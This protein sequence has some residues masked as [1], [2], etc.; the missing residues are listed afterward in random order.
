MSEFELIPEEVYE[1]LPQD[2]HEKFASI[3]RVAQSN[4][5]RLLDTPSSRDFYDE[6]RAQFISA[7]SGV[8]EALGIDGLPPIDDDITEYRSYANFQI[9]LA[10]I[11]ARV[12]LQSN[13]VSRPHSVELGRITRA[14]IKQEIDQ[15]RKYIEYSD[16]PQEKRESLA[17]KLDEFEKELEARRMSFARVMAISASIMTIIGAGTTALAN[18][19]KAADAII[20]IIHWVGED[21]EKEESERLRLMPPPKALPDFTKSAQWKQRPVSFA[22]EADDDIPF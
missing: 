12:R 6:I 2:P 16:I 8:A 5:A 4:L 18:S 13:L 1:N 3:V 21:K 11:V 17:V 22:D 10:G 9:R 14:R 7:I 15:L 19:P 20:R